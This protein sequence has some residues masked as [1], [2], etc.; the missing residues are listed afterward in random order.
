MSTSTPSPRFYNRPLPVEAP[1]TPYD[2]KADSNPVLKGMPLVIFAWLFGKLDFLQK[3]L[4]KNAGFAGL[5]EL[6]LHAYHPR[7]DPTVIPIS[8]PSSRE[9]LKF[10]R[11]SIPPSPSPPA[12]KWRYYSV[13][14]YHTLFLSGELTPL[15]V[16]EALLP[17]IR[18]DVTPR[19]AHSTAFTTLDV[20]SILAAASASTARYAAGKPLSIF[21]GVPTALKDQTDLAGYP[22]SLGRALTPQFPV[23]ETSTF[24][25]QQWEKLGGIMVG[26]L[27]MHEIGADTTNNNPNWGTPLNP[28]H[29]GYYTG[30]SSGGAAYAVAAGLLPF[31]LGTDGGGSVRLPSS[32]CGIF[33]LKPSHGRLEDMGSSVTVTGPL[34]SS[35]NDI[36]LAYRM[37]SVPDPGS[38][39]SALFPAPA[40]A[41]QGRPRRIG[42]CKGWFSR[43]ESEVQDLC[44]DAV[45][46]YEGLGY[47]IIDIEMPYVHKGQIAHAMTILAEMVGRAREHSRNVYKSSDHA[48][49]LTAPN[50]ILLGLGAQ[51]PASDYLLAQQLR[52]LLMS[53]LSFLF[54][55]YEGMIIVTPTTPLK[56]WE[57][58]DGELD[59]GCSNGDKSV[60]SMEFAWFANFTGCPALSVP[61]GFV[62]PV[63]GAGEGRVPVGLMGM[64]EWASED[65]LIAWGREAESYLI[66]GYP[67]GRPQPQNWV[68][69]ISL[70]KEKKIGEDKGK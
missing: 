60:R 35:M 64:G 55:K 32:F 12:G 17:L 21:D 51:T 5:R 45:R 2:K 29:N 63:K 7:Y 19:T 57:I 52:S 37:M 65:S 53:H 33:G 14:D 59:Y 56:G 67:G 10:E 49:G 42:I 48:S 30:G 40:P 54:G 13:T 26:K 31:A 22:T 15:A 44:M 28:Y 16:I 27:N 25:V 58:G 41:P 62:D 11:S 23:S 36:E 3:V 47:E 70:A 50:K 46:R 69:V 1:I 20:P 24:A 43:A 9:P 66:D 61:V 4:W 6:E 8:D 68:D 34:A 18:R 38:A 39:S